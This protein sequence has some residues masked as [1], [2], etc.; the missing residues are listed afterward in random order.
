MKA[1]N[2]AGGWRA[3]VSCRGL[4]PDV[5]SFKT[6][7]GAH[8]MVKPVH[9]DDREQE[10][11]ARKR[12]LEDVAVTKKGAEAAIALAALL[13]AARMRITSARLQDAQRS[14]VDKVD[15]PANAEEEEV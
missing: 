5:D 8:A 4:Q 14:V 12:I 6:K 7:L 3:R 13:P 15:E 11:T 2:F 10:Q 1:I 9:D